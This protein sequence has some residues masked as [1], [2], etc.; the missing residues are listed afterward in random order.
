[1][2]Y[3]SH[4]RYFKSRNPASTKIFA[5]SQIYF[6][7]ILRNKSETLGYLAQVGCPLHATLLSTFRDRPCL[8]GGRKCPWISHDNSSAGILIILVIPK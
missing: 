4:M 1:M 6:E 2:E 8:L 5:E 3:V 7:I